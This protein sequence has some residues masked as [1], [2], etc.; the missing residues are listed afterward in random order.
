MQPPT[1]HRTSLA[2]EERPKLTLLFGYVGDGQTR[3]TMPH[4]ADRWRKR[5]RL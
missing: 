1:Y 2:L 5:L 3:E 4:T